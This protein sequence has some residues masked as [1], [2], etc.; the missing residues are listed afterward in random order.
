MITAALNMQLS[1]DS[2]DD[3]EIDKLIEQTRHKKKPIAQ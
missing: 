1:S 3:D 2:S